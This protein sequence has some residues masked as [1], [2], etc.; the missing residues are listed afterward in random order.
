M[1]KPQLPDTEDLSLRVSCIKYSTARIKTQL[2]PLWP[3]RTFELPLRKQWEAAL[4]SRVPP[5][6]PA[7]NM[8]LSISF[9]LNLGASRQAH[10]KSRGVSERLLNPK[11]TEYQREILSSESKCNRGVDAKHLEPWPHSWPNSDPHQPNNIDTQYSNAQFSNT[12]YSNIQIFKYS[13]FKYSILKN[14]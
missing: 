14:I 5:S 6:W 3:H 1:F 11:K 4:R 7:S 10:I 12:K 13:I 8:F 2:F 9:T